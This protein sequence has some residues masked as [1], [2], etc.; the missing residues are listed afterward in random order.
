MPMNASSPDRHMKNLRDMRRQLDDLEVQLQTASGSDSFKQLQAAVDAVPDIIYRID[1]ESRIVFISKAVTRYGLDPDALVGTSLFDLIHP[2]DRERARHRV[3]DRRTG[4]RSTRSFELRLVFPNDEI[5]AFELNESATPPP[6]VLIDA[7]GVYSSDV[8]RSVDFLYT[9]GVAR[10]ITDRRLAAAALDETRREAAQRLA[11]HALQI[12]TVTRQLQQQ[13]QV[14]ERHEAEAEVIQHIRDEIWRLI[15]P[16]Q[17]D[18]VLRAIRDGLR[19]LGVDFHAIGINDVDEA[20]GQVR[21]N[22]IVGDRCEWSLSDDEEQ[23]ARVVEFMKTGLP[24]YRP[25][26]HEEDRWQ[27]RRRVEEGWGPPIRSIVD[28]PLD[29]GT[30]A[31][32][33]R[34]AHAFSE[35]DLKLLQK[36]AG[37]LQEGVHRMRDLRALQ[38]RSR[39]A[40]RLAAE[41]QEALEREVVLSR[42]RD[43]ILSMHSLSDVPQHRDMI[44]TLR[45]LGVPADGMSMQFPATVEG[46]YETFHASDFP[47]P[48]ASHALDDHPWVRQVWQTGKSV[49]VPS[50]QIEKSGFQDWEKWCIL[51]VP[52][53]GGGSLGVNRQ[54]GGTFSDDMIRTVE[55]FAA[56]V[57]AGLQRLRDSERLEESEK[58]HRLLVESLPLGVVH[59]TPA[60]RMIYQNAA[61]RK[62]FGYSDKDLSE[63]SLEH[64]YVNPRDREEMVQILQETQSAKFEHPMRHKSDR[65]IW[66]RG[67]S[68]LVENEAS[69]RIEIHGVFEDVTERKKMEAH[70]ARLEEQL[71]QSQ[72]MEAVGQ[73]TAGI[74]H[75]FNNMLQ[76]ISGNLQLAILDAEGEMR[77][78]LLD[79]DRVTHRAADMIQQLMVFTRQGMK[80]VIGSVS[81]EPIIRNTIDICRRTFDRK[82]VIEADL[83]EDARVVGDPGLLQQVFLNMLINAR[84]AV[85]D[86]GSESPWIRLNM[87]TVLVSSEEASA[88]I[89]A[90]EGPCLEITIRDNGI[91]MDAETQRRIFEPFFTTKPVD[92]GTGL[93]LATVYGIIKQ[94]QGWVTCESQ[95][96]AGTTFCIYLPLGTVE[97]EVEEM[98][99]AALQTNGDQRTLLIIDDED[100]VRETTT[101]LLERHGF[102]VLAADSGPAGLKMVVEEDACIDLILLDLSMP[103]MSGHE[104]LAELRRL[105]PDVKVVIITGYAAVE[106]DVEG[107]D[108]IL[109]KPFSVAALL[110]RIDQVLSS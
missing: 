92:R 110:G 15:D 63:V 64:L 108:G 99:S 66:V 38:E 80:P 101:R 77:Q 75:N 8:P 103:S 35:S 6:N 32:N 55:A 44:A 29:S 22:T 31:I 1:S 7:R 18:D 34:R 27:E 19:D 81:L 109:Q 53:P 105:R 69:G 46:R 39:E 50:E 4:E 59:S 67:T 104:V 60:G 9:Q 24:T 86:G 68:T 41:R 65:Q 14:R 79:A 33:S 95:P 89:D 43:H 42:L 76:G 74:A 17:I 71:R 5:V 87:A 13:I 106:V 36:I 100:A 52:L 102:H 58:R 90:T 96:G 26:L 94:H 51:E 82:I 73:L 83:A 70:N 54:D 84:D 3:N 85:L 37:V 49:V 11:E 45:D 40:E 28:L 56:V 91:G 23:N 57:A 20:A 2:E 21:Y 62:I 72:K 16:D 30:L 12:R 97:D 93:G 107:A 61:A 48:S 25:D 47:Q 78:M 10:N 88:Y 98:D